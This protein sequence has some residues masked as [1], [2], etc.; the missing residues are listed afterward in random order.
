[1]PSG[2]DVY[3]VVVLSA[4]LALGIPIFLRL[5]SGLIIR[6]RPQ[7]SGPVN[8]LLKGKTEEPRSVLAR[9]INTRF[10]LAANAS[11]VLVAL[12]LTL[13]PCVDAIQAA[14]E[15]QDLARI[16]GSIVTLAA[17]A[18]CALLYSARKGDLNWLKSLR[19]DKLPKELHE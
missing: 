1:M 8:P 18:A 6:R 14:G 5:V 12:A 2:W 13:V 15:G 9:R 7:P 3:Y 16:L 4:L 10:F 11:L 19:E 17:L